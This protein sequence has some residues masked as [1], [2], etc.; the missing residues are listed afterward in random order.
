MTIGNVWCLGS[1]FGFRVPTPYTELV[2]PE[3]LLVKSMLSSSG[4][5]PVC[6]CNMEGCVNTIWKAKDDVSLHLYAAATSRHL[7]WPP[8]PGWQVI[9]LSQIHPPFCHKA[10]PVHREPIYIDIHIYARL[11]TCCSGL[12]Q[13]M[14]GSW[15]DQPRDAR[16]ASLT[17]RL[18]RS[19]HPPFRH[20]AKPGCI[21]TFPG[22]WGSADTNTSQVRLFRRKQLDIQTRVD[23]HDV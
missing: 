1:Y 22:T 16:T 13:A 2:I 6:Q 21:G 15:L 11:Q 14:H 9:D 20:M 23:T 12:Q 10:K 3:Q 18:P 5:V 17:C 7:S 19:H 8:R 4:R